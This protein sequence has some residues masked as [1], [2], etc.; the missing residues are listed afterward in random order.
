MVFASDMPFD[1]EGGSG[2]IRWTLEAIDAMELSDA[3]RHELLVGQA[4][5]LL[6]GTLK[7]E[8]HA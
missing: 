5:R 1:P 6:A 2:Y 8:A 3:Q 7:K 4:E